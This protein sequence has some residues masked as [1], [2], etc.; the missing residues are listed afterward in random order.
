MK[1]RTLI[2][3]AVATGGVASFGALAGCART[4]DDGG[5]GATGGTNETTDTGDTANDSD[6]TTTD[7]GDGDGDGGTAT[8]TVRT[9]TVDPYGEILTDAEGMTLYLFTKDEGGASV[10]YDDCATAWPPLTASGQPSA[11]T[12]VTARLGTAE[13][14]DGST[15]VT[16]A[17][18]PLYYYEPDEAPGDAKGQG[19][20]GVWFVVGPDGTRVTEGATGGTDTPGENDTSSDDGTSGGGA[21]GGNG[22][23]S[24]GG[25]GGGYY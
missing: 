9:A 15:Q 12:G 11:G 7:T 23:G 4:G 10:C 22:S 19:V 17:G 8:A 2:R 5:D 1:R 14:T 16:A 25:S 3:G 18:H 20:G 24:D 6:D 21:D 13:R